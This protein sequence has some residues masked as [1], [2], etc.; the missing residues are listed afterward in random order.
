MPRT[1]NSWQPFWTR[2]NSWKP[3]STPRWTE[4]TTILTSA[5]L[6]S[7]PEH[8]LTQFRVYLTDS[9]THAPK[10]RTASSRATT[11]H[12]THAPK[13]R[14]ASSRATTYHHTHAPKFRTASS[15]TTTT[16]CHFINAPELRTT[17]SRT[18]F[19]THPDRTNCTALSRSVSNQP[20]QYNHLPIS[21]HIYATS[22]S[23]TR[24]VR[25]PTS[26]IWQR[27]QHTYIANYG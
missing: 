7:L 8:P 2:W 23:S 11:Y 27:N 13:S 5:L 25:S 6:H 9:Y 14:T 20:D 3:T 16:T 18:T 19:T 4:C 1:E 22:S 12:H 15:R 26:R 10:S 24:Q 17:E 21:G